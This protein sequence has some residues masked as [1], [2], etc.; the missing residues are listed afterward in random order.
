MK[1]IA[2]YTIPCMFLLLHTSGL[3]AQK[4]TLP[5]TSDNAMSNRHCRSFFHKIKID[6][7]DISSVEQ[8]L[9]NELPAMHVQGMSLQRGAVI[10]SQK[11]R[12]Y[13]FWQS[14]L[15]VPVYNAQ[16][17][18]NLDED[19]YLRSLFDNTCHATALP[20]F[21]FPDSSLVAEKLK[22]SIEPYERCRVQAVWFPAT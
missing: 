5:F 18:A 10:S 11:G 19:G 14:Y 21:V 20:P 7:D 8:Y 2:C 22:D 17:K 3:H 15:G 6:G 16:V 4:N 13:T 9:M 1:R 12:H